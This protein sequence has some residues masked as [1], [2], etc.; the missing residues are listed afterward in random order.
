MYGNHASCRLSE[1][2]DS[3]ATFLNAI[4]SLLWPIFAF[5]VL[6]MFR[7]DLKRILSRVRKGKFLGTEF[8]LDALQEFASEAVIDVAA[9]PAPSEPKVLS[10]MQNEVVKKTNEIS[11]RSPKAALLFIS[12]EIEREIRNILGDVYQD[13]RNKKRVLSLRTGLQI[14]E[15]KDVLPATVRGSVELFWQLRNRLA[16]GDEVDSDQI[17]TMIGAGMLIYESLIALPKVSIQ[18]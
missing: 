8:E 15:E 7:S 10:V 16:H 14:L 9:L 17:A 3:A 12:G 5:V 18:D 2:M 11:S 4:A 6:W 1:K 13:D